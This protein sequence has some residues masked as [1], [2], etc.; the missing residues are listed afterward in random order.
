MRRAR[1]GGRLSSLG[2]RGA[3]G[4]CAGLQSW[5]RAKSGACCSARSGGGLWMQTD[6]SGRRT[7]SGD[8]SNLA[9]QRQLLWLRKQ[10][11]CFKSFWRI[12]AEREASSLPCQCSHLA[13]QVAGSRRGLLDHCCVL[14]GGVV[15]S[16]ERSSDLRHGGRLR[17]IVVSRLAECRVNFANFFRDVRQGR[18]DLPGR[19]RSLNDVGLGGRELV[20]RLLRFFLRPHGQGAD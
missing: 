2:A 3:E 17:Q 1:S 14:L 4:G 7:S 10:G 8:A 5:K 19:A 9:Y 6:R 11:P 16:A 13:R 12:C 15:Q 20:S 18:I